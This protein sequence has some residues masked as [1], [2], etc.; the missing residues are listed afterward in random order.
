MRRDP[1]RD[2]RSP[3]RSATPV[4]TSLIVP[5]IEQH[6]SNEDWEE[7]RK[8]WNDR[9]ASGEP[10]HSVL[11]DLPLKATRD[12]TDALMLDSP[13]FGLA[14]FDRLGIQRVLLTADAA[15]ALTSPC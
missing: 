10:M 6:M 7:T 11:L 15:K 14:G 1:V 12:E 4:R 3:A 13:T 8:R 5:E 9:L 2:E